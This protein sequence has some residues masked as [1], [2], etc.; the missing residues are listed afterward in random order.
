MKPTS[1]PIPIDLTRYAGMIGGAREFLRVWAADE[2]PVTCFINP[3]PLG[4]DPFAFGMALV[5]CV[6]NGAK[7]YAKAVN[8]PEAEALARIWEG[9]DTERAMPTD[10]PSDVTPTRSADGVIEFVPPRKVN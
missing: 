7:A 6:R 9:L 10:Q 3:V 4:P 2:G 5:D 8:I 1:K